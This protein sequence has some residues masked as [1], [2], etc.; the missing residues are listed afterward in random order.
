MSPLTKKP[1][2]P[3]NS[4]VADHLL[5][6]LKLKE[7]LLIIRDKAPLIGTLRRHYCTYST[8]PSN[9]IFARILFAFHSCYI[10][11]NERTFYYFAMC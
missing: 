4:S 6:L 3:K 9:K 8:G 5:F 10:I 7:S 1:F 11:L 2:K